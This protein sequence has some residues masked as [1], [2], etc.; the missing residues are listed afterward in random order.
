M[1]MEKPGHSAAALLEGASSAAGQVQG[2]VGSEAIVPRMEGRQGQ[3]A[4]LREKAC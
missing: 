3:S 4:S 1:A 2:Q